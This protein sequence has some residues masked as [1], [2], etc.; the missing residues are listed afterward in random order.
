M[1][2]IQELCANPG[3]WGTVWNQNINCN[4]KKLEIKIGLLS[5]EALKSENE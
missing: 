5:T 3:N 4:H 2:N 1:V